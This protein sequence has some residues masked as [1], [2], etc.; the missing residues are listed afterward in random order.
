MQDEFDD[1]IEDARIKEQGEEGNPPAN[2]TEAGT[3]TPQGEQTPNNNTQTPKPTAKEILGLEEDEEWDSIKQKLSEVSDLRRKAELAEGL[4]KAV[5]AN[6]KVAG[7][8]EF[9]K[10]HPQIENFGFYEGVSNLTAEDPIQVLTVKWILDNPEYVGKEEMV[11]RMLTKEYK[12]DTSLFSEEEVEM[13]KMKLNRAA[14]DAF[15]EIEG[16]RQT[17]K[18]PSAPTTEDLGK[19]ETEW[20][21][22]VSEELGSFDKLPIPILNAQTGKPELYLEF[23]IPKEM[24]SSYEAASVKAYAQMANVDEKTKSR[25]KSDFV[26]SF[27][28]NNF[29]QISHAIKTKAAADER[30][31]VE[32]E[33]D[34]AGALRSERKNAS[35]EQGEEDI[36]DMAFG[37]LTD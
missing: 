12:V 9:L 15:T 27:L 1:L 8:N 2:T 14:K 29:A 35:G 13:N 6:E 19:R 5:F 31:A 21:S 28:Y 11:S 34:G 30:A 26:Q 16:L 24:R 4:P 33:Y 36:Y 25:I 18:S 17:F 23:E 7:Y 3:G 10:K 37:K 20:K 22:A 32:L